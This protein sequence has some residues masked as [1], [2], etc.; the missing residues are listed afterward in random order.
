MSLTLYGIPNCDSVKKARQWL[1]QHGVDYRFHDFRKDG[2]EADLVNL[3]IKRVG[4]DI[5]LNRRGTT[6]R[7]LDEQHKADPDAASIAGLLLEYPTL[8]KRPVVT[9]GSQVLVGFDRDAWQSLL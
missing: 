1:E 8:I 7:Q 5:L 9:K 3:W 4:A 6:W 2:L